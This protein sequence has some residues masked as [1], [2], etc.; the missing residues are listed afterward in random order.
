MENNGNFVYY[1]GFI[2][3]YFLH[4]ME[5]YVSKYCIQKC[6]NNKNVGSFSPDTK[7]LI[8]G[9]MKAYR[10][11]ACNTASFSGFLP[12][13]A[14]QRKY[15]LYNFHLCLHKCFLRRQEVRFSAYC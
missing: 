15:T 12:F 1:L 8:F 7:L 4:K 5:K 6:G 10:Q 14:V 3:R 2:Y 11:K 9:F 13:P